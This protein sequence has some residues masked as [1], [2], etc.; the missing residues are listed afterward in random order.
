MLETAQLTK[1]ELLQ[2]V[3]GVISSKKLAR[4]TVSYR[5]TDGTECIKYH[6]TVVVKKSPDGIITLSLIHI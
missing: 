3:E 4:N 5:L 6:D 1:K 2:G